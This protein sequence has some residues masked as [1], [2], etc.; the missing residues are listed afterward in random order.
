MGQGDGEIHGIF[1]SATASPVL[2][3]YGLNTAQSS[4]TTNIAN[5]KVH[6][7]TYA[8]NE[9]ISF[10][11]FGKEIRWNAFMGSVGEPS[12]VDNMDGLGSNVHYTRCITIDVY[13]ALD[14]LG[15]DS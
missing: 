14:Y 10:H 15:C 7:L 2:F 6:W 9:W 5:V 1:S 3:T 13:L 12:A 11:H 4:S 8:M